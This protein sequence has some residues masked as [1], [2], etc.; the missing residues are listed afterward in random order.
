MLAINLTSDCIMPNLHI[1]IG[2]ANTR[3]SSLL[4]CLTGCSSSNTTVKVTQASGKVIDVYCKIR[5][6]QEKTQ[7]NPPQNLNPQQFIQE[8]KNLPNTPTDIAITL[9]VKPTNGCLGFGAYL[10]AFSAIGWSVVNVALLENSSNIS[11]SSISA[12]NVVSVPNSKTQPTSQT[13]SHVR[14]AWKWM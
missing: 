14:Q 8:I 7:K 10:N 3:K 13:S 1:I 5:S 2:D 11:Q 9:R 4:R 12:S 6:L